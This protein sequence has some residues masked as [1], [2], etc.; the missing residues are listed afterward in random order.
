MNNNPFVL[1]SQIMQ[2]GMSPEQ[3]VNMMA[4]RNPQ[5]MYQIQALKQQNPNKTYEQIAIDMC[6]QKGVDPNQM[7]AMLRGMK[8]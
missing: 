7:M 1:M 5:L 2:K 4:Q 3:L 8:K 6:K